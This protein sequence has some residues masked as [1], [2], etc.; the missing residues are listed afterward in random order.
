MGVPG[1][2]QNVVVVRGAHTHNP[3]KYFQLGAQ[4]GSVPTSM[5]GRRPTVN[6]D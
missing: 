6:H 2:S 1:S 3:V 4:T 5:G